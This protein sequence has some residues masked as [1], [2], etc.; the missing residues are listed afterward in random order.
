M[1]EYLPFLISLVFFLICLASF[2]LFPVLEKNSTNRMVLYCT[3]SLFFTIILFLILSCIYYFE[4]LDEPD[5][6]FRKKFKCEPYFF[7][8]FISEEK[9]KSRLIEKKDVFSSWSDFNQQLKDK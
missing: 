1:Y 6:V 4:C 9:Y 5:E 3:Y 2:L 7:P 8:D